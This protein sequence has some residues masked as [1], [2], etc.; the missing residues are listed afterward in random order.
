MLINLTYQDLHIQ[1]SMS[2]YLLF[3]QMTIREPLSKLKEKDCK[4][5]TPP[6]LV[7]KKTSSPRNESDKLVDV[8]EK[9]WAIS[10]KTTFYTD[11]L[12]LE[13]LKSILQSR[14]QTFRRSIPTASL[15][16]Q[17]TLKIIK[18]VIQASE[19]NVQ[20]WTFW[21]T[22]SLNLGDWMLNLLHSLKLK[23]S[24]LQLIP[25]WKKSTCEMKVQFPNQN[26]A[27]FT[28]RR[29]LRRKNSSKL[30]KSL[31]SYQCAEEDNCQDNQVWWFRSSEGAVDQTTS[32]VDW[33]EKLVANNLY[34]CL[35]RLSI[36]V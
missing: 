30:A 6:M 23:N 32:V 17:L 5:A 34:V 22:T 31:G 21:E 2:S 8:D 28:G 15:R 19:L 33:S 36:K 16:S 24:L 11:T 20:L 35:W 10:D 26:L 14:M 18:P 29:I 9:S 4:L 7:L 1:H 12:S 13:I 27:T 3:I 25:H